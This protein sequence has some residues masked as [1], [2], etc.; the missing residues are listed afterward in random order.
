MPYAHELTYWTI[1]TIGGL[2]S[3]L[4][5]YMIRCRCGEEFYAETKDAA[6]TFL[7][8]H[9]REGGTMANPT[10]EIKS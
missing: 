8:S 9:I 2:L 3:N 5:L 7:I 1:K 6:E 4:R 10:G